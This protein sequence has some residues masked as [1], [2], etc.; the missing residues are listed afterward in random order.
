MNIILLLAYLYFCDSYFI[1]FLFSPKLSHFLNLE[2]TVL[3]LH[4]F[5]FS[6]G[7]SHVIPLP[8]LSGFPFPAF[9]L[10]LIIV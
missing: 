7:L 3:F 8:S 1:A 4:K 10:P 6:Q 9:R 5:F 2:Q